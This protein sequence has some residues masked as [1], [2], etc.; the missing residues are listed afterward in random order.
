MMVKFF[1][2]MAEKALLTYQMTG[3]M[4]KRTAQY[5]KKN[6]F[7]KGYSKQMIMEKA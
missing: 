3:R 2:H 7:S 6:F 5:G 4:T 1:L